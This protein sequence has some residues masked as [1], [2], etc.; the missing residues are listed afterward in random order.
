M[1]RNR[2]GLVGMIATVLMM[3]LSTSCKTC[4]T[5]APAVQ[6]PAP[7]QGTGTGRTGITVT[8]GAT[9]SYGSSPLSVT[10]TDLE[11][12]ST[13]QAYEIQQATVY[14]E[15]SNSVSGSPPTGTPLATAT[16]INSDYYKF[17]ASVLN[18]TAVTHDPALK[19]FTIWVVIQGTD[20]SSLPHS[21]KPY[22]AK[23]V[24]NPLKWD[25]KE[26]VVIAP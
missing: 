26:F 14:V 8:G 21:S 13:G 15:S 19:Y 2:V 5:T 1:A 4:S 25:P 9:F 18:T 10:L 23:R 17:P 24:F 20:T 11:L 22:N 6:P 3:E 7:V 16:S 12:D